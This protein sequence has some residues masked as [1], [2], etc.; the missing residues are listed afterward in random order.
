M[1]DFKLVRG[2]PG[3]YDGYHSDG[4]MTYTRLYDPF[5]IKD[6]PIDFEV[7]VGWTL[8]DIYAKKAEGHVLLFNVMQDP[9]ERND[10]SAQM[11][12]KV[13]EMAARMDEYLAE[14]RPIDL[15]HQKSNPAAWS[16]G[17]VWVPGWCDASVF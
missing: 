7:P 14:A 10:L 12:D 1:G 15:E 3:A 5:G 4:T 13:A 2:N 6:D 8:D 17:G 11:P 9:E 16:F